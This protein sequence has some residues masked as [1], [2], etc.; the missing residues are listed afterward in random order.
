MTVTD[1][2][3]HIDFGIM[4]SMW[5]DGDR[6]HELPYRAAEDDRRIK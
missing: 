3:E 4:L 6:R 1:R 5:T 2:I